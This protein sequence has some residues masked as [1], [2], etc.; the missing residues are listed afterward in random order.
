MD[1]LAPQ[2]SGYRGEW[3]SSA[4]L[5]SFMASNATAIVLPIA[6]APEEPTVYPMTTYAPG[7]VATITG[8]VRSAPLTTAGVLRLV[9]A[10]APETWTVIGFI[11]GGLVDGQYEWLARW[12]NGKWEYT[13]K[14]NVKTGPAPAPDSTP[15]S[16]ADVAKAVADN[17]AK[18][19][20][21]VAT[22]P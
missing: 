13:S 2:T 21:W 19:E 20:A 14:T 1:P 6:V 3:V 8:N 17:E 15:L 12:A 10:T 7:Q 5:A 22:H 18:W 16:Q 11:K 4:D 9:P